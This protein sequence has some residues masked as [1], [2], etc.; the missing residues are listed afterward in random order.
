MI[1]AAKNVFDQFRLDGRRALVTGG[2]KGLGRV[3]ATTF[4]AAGAD[5]VLVSRTLVECEA[6]ASAITTETGCKALAID[7][8]VTRAEDVDRLA[9]D[10]GQIDILVNSAG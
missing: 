3:I 5:V 2:S 6:T 1:N 10:A 4:A 8:D 9:R 7:A